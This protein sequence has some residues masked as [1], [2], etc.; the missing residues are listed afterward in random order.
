[1][2]LIQFREPGR[3]GVMQ[4]LDVPI[5][6]GRSSDPGPCDRRRYAGLLDPSWDL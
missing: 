6:V 4:C 3:P 5:P 1:M 2:R